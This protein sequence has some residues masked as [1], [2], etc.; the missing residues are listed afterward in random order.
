MILLGKTK[1]KKDSSYS[2]FRTSAVMERRAESRVDF[3]KPADKAEDSAKAKIN[4]TTLLRSAMKRAWWKDEK[5]KNLNLIILKSSLINQ[6]S[7]SKVGEI[8]SEKVQQQV[9]VSGGI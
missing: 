2:G 7:L 4:K 6:N 5:N 1:A 9:S 8:V 3:Q